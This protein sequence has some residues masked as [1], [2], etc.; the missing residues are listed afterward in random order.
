M[1]FRIMSCESQIR[2][3]STLISLS[4]CAPEV[5]I[6]HPM[7]NTLRAAPACGHFYDIHRV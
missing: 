5:G 4:A 6:Y 7:R 3:P 2:Y 1:V